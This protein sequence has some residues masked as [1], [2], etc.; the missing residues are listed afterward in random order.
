[1]L[2][3]CGCAFAPNIEFL[4]CSRLLQGIGAGTSAVVAFAMV[5]DIYNSEQSAKL[6]GMMNS[7]ITVFMSAA[8]IA[9][10]FINKS[11]G[12]R[13]TTQQLL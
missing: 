1:M 3:A 10:S 12:W 8:P 13:V 9:G 11:L 5:A 7:M 4:L 2:G 6:I